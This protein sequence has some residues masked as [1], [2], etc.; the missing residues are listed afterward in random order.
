MTPKKILLTLLV[1][2][3]LMLSIPYALAKNQDAQQNKEKPN[4][5]PVEDTEEDL[6]EKP[7]TPKAMD[8]GFN[9]NGKA[10]H[11]YLV[12][13]DVNWDIVNDGAWGKMN[14]KEDMF[15]FNAHGLTPGLEYS[16]VYYPDPWPG[17]GLIELGK[18]TVDA[19]GNIHI[20]AS[21][22]F[23]GIPIKGDENVP[24]AKI[25]LVLTD[26]INFGS[27]STPNSMT[28]WNPVEYLFEYNMINPATLFGRK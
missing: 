8:N 19:D 27:D 20:K 10:K 16:L 15:V 12:E 5:P 7:V 11:L 28:G 2:A 13:K 26:D 22:D 14:F 25:W 4:V 9:G 1:I 21:F 17:T 18:S 23:M 6:K 3:S 24:A